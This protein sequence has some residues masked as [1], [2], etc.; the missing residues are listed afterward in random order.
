M[1]CRYREIS[2]CPGVG[3]TQKDILS[4]QLPQIKNQDF[5]TENPFRFCGIRAGVMMRK[6]T[7]VFK[8]DS[9][10]WQ[11]NTFL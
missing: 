7:T 1:G 11:H 3:H 10:P 5:T 9:Y 6:I 4:L 2:Y 8:C